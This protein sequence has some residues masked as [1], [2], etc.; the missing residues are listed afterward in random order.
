MRH[1][2]SV[3]LFPSFA[4]AR[5]RARDRNYDVRE[6]RGQRGSLKR[7]MNDDS[8]GRETALARR[9]FAW[10]RRGRPSAVLSRFAFTV[11]AI[12]SRCVRSITRGQ[13]ASCQRL[14]RHF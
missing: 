10:T 13:I 14:G 8:A 1:H 2:R 9:E 6:R 4:P 12:D 3:D 5:A 11:L 7:R